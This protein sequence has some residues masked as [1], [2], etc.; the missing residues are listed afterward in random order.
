[1]EA[2]KVKTMKT[3]SKENMLVKIEKK[4]DKRKFVKE[5]IKFQME[6]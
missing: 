1:M 4:G 5:N 2:V 6:Q 3:F